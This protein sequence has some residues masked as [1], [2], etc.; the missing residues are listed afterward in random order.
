MSPLRE[1]GKGIDAELRIRDFRTEDMADVFDLY[2]RAWEGD[3]ARRRTAFEWLMQGPPFREGKDGYLL[4]F[5]GD[6]LAGYWGRMPVRLRYRGEPLTCVFNQEALVDPGFRSQGIARAL[7]EEAVRGP[8]LYLSLWHNE[9]IVSLLESQGW[10][11]LG[12][13]ATRKRI[14]RT[15]GLIRWKTGSGGLA[16]VVGPILDFVMGMRRATGAGEVGLEVERGGRF[17]ERVDHLFQPVAPVLGFVAER[18]REILNWR[19][20]DIPHRCFELH[21]ATGTDGRSR[22]YLVTE[23]QPLDTDGLRRGDIVDFLVHPEDDEAIGSLLASADEEFR[24]AEVDFAVLLQTLTTLGPAL[25]HWRFRPARNPGAPSQLL[26][27]DRRERTLPPPGVG[28]DEWYLT[29]GDSDGHLW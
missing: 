8:N 19:Y 22:G 11:T 23:I 24:E 18:S 9:K 28:Y 27:L 4:A 12:R 26:F 25:D 14:Y 1:S 21:R 29:H 7:M 2:D 5:K 20:V 13:Y 3:V 16:T 17:N 10:A 6:V 15:E